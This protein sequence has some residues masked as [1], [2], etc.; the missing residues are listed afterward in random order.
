LKLSVN[1][2]GKNAFKRVTIDT[3]QTHNELHEKERF[4]IAFYNSRDRNVGYN[5]LEG[6]E[7]CPFKHT[8]EA[9]QKIS[10]ALRKRK[11]SDET[12]RKIANSMKGKRNGLGH[13]HVMKEETKAKLRGRKLSAE[14]K[15]KIS[16][17]MKNRS[18]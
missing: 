11:L 3:A 10:A 8:D 12:K 1:K 7:G 6:G 15:R 13:T 17:T 5:I 2:H 18:Q 9:K 14:H 4:W 16:E